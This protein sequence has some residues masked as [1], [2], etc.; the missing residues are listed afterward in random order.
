MVGS[1]TSSGKGRNGHHTFVASHILLWLPIHFCGFPQEMFGENFDWPLILCQT[2]ER[3][4]FEIFVA[5][6]AVL[7]MSQ[8]SRSCVIASM[9]Y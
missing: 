8:I 4:D 9:S 6:Q 5:G 7:Q 1:I 2:F 3:K